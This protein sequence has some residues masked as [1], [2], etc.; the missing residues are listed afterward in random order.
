M[1]EP[2]PILLTGVGEIDRQRREPFEREDALLEATRCRLSRE[3]V[4]RTIELLGAC[5]VD[6]FAAEE[7]GGRVTEWLRERIHRTDRLLGERLRA[8][9]G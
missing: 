1:L 2:G 6:R 4:L 3:E 9:P 5:A 7:R 8:H